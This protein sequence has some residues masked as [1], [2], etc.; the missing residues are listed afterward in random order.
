MGQGNCF[1]LSDDEH[2]IRSVEIIIIIIIIIIIN[3][4]Y[5]GYLQIHT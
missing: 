5:A 4:H 3:H 2:Y 1:I